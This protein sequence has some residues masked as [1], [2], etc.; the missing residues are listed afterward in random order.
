MKIHRALTC[1]LLLGCGEST[2]E[3]PPEVVCTAERSDAEPS[4]VE[5]QKLLGKDALGDFVRGEWRTFGTTPLEIAEALGAHVD[6]EEDNVYFAEERQ[7]RFDGQSFISE[8]VV[9]RA[10]LSECGSADPSVFVV[11]T[12]PADIDG[13]SDPLLLNPTTEIMARDRKT[14]LFNFYSIARAATGYVFRRWVEEPSGEIRIHEADE[15]FAVTERVDSEGG[16]FY[17]HANGAPMLLEADGASSAWRSGASSTERNYTGTTARL[18]IAAAPFDALV[19]EV[20]KSTSTHISGSASS[21]GYVRRALDGALGGGT[22]RLLKS[23]FCPTEYQ[24]VSPGPGEAPLA[25][26]ADPALLGKSSDSTLSVPN[27]SLR[28][29]PVRAQADLEVERRLVET[30]VISEAVLLAIRLLEPRRDLDRRR[31]NQYW[32]LVPELPEN[33]AEVDD[34]LRGALRSLWANEETSE[35]KTLALALLEGEPDG[36]DMLATYRIELLNRIESE[37]QTATVPVLENR[38][39]SRTAWMFERFIPPFALNPLFYELWLNE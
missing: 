14:G 2:Q 31:C 28:W 13:N 27:A 12:S 26:F 38:A 4:C 33:A 34:Y 7:T 3:M 25:Y 30:G 10:I 6:C 11:L 29:A 18:H 36:P 23:L 5:E 16:C 19:E 35:E 8:E 9:P 1:A 24:V 21:D 20:R 32:P 17:C 15:T 37:A 22:G 39:R